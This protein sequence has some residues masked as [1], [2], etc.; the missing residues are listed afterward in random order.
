[1]K[2]SSIPVKTQ[3]VEKQ[4]IAKYS[5]TDVV[6]AITSIGIPPFPQPDDDKSFKSKKDFFAML[7][8]IEVIA[9]KR[10]QLDEEI[11]SQHDKRI[12]PLMARTKANTALLNDLTIKSNNL[13]KEIEL[14]KHKLKEQKNKTA[15]QILAHQNEIREID[16]KI[17]GIENPIISASKSQS[18]L[19]SKS[20]FD[21]K[22]PTRKRKSDGL[23]T[24]TKKLIDGY[25]SENAKPQENVIESSKPKKPKT[26]SLAKT[27]IRHNESLT[28]FPRNEIK[29][30][31]Q[32][33]NHL[34]ISIPTIE[35]SL[36]TEADT[37]IHQDLRKISRTRIPTRP[38]A[39]TAQV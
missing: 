30:Q 10:R 12:E 34:S 24:G 38:R 3:P 39:T 11:E 5:Y 28:S 6:D 37:S 7:K 22:V 25:K 15:E 14:Q 23:K 1:M 18:Q 4:H 8:T 31:I 9:F 35:E 16:A 20:Q 26:K 32:A 19:T 17:N 27:V 21:V 13:K 33:E 29:L 2:K 36:E